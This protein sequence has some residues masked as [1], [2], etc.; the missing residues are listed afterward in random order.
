MQKVGMDHQ[1]VKKSINS[2]VL[3]VFFLPLV[4]ASIHMVF[5]FPIV[6]R[7]LKVLMFDNINLLVI[8]TICC[9]GAF[10]VAYVLVYILTSKFYYQIVKRDEV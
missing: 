9:I 3:M 8:C 4:M 5:A 6:S 7:L 10:S 2:Q 1:T